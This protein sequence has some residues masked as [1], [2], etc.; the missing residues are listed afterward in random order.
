LAYWTEQ[1]LARLL[2]LEVLWTTVLEIR[3]SMV[4]VTRSAKTLVT[5]SVQ[6]SAMA[7]QLGVA[8]RDIDQGS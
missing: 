7:S 3:S 1:V 5:R 6:V 8:V 4:L 2:V